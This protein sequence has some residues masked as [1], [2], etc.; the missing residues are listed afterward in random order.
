[1]QLMEHLLVYGLD[2]QYLIYIPDSVDKTEKVPVII[3]L[4][5]TLGSAEQMMGFADFRPLADRDQFLIVCPEGITQTWNDGRA[6]KANKAGIDDVSFIDQLISHLI[7]K[8]PVDE[9]CIYVTGMS[10]GGFMASRLACEIPERIAA[11]AAVAATLDKASYIRPEQSMPV[12]YIHG[13]KDNIVPFAGGPTKA[14]GGNVFGHEELLHLW[15]NVN[16]CV[17]EPKVTEIGD[18]AGDGTKIIKHEYINPDNVVKV[19]GYTV[20][21]GGHTWPGRPQYAPVN[22][23]G[24]VS[25][26]LNACEEIWRFFKQYSR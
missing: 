16:N 17:D 11:I 13:T 12:L 7:K 23:V 19:I 25:N 21:N 18:R 14:A 5:G 2:R 9:R 3:S 24:M 26:N 20:V 10:N 6:T 15:V 4:H 1:M 22:F 8:Y